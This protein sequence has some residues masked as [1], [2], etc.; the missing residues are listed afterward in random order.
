VPSATTGN[1]VLIG[2]SADTS[3]VST[4]PSGFGHDAHATGV[5]HDAAGN[6][7]VANAPMKPLSTSRPIPQ[8]ALGAVKSIGR[9]L[10][11]FHKM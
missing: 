8:A 7:C 6:R 5:R 2:I 4:A 11:S 1:T 3:W 9:G 10:R